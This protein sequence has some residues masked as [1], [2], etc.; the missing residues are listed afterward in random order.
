MFWFNNNRSG[1]HK[2]IEKIDSLIRLLFK[3]HN[4]NTDEF[5]SKYHDINIWG[6]YKLQCLCF[7]NDLCNNNLILPF[8]QLIL[9]ILSILISLIG[10]QIFI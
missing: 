7:M 5:Q 8:F 4:L 3:K 9:I 6:V 10:M 1:K 2:L